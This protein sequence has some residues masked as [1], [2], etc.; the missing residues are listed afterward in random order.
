MQVIISSRIPK[1]EF[2]VSVFLWHTQRS[3]IAIEDL[4][5][6]KT[7]PKFP[8]PF[9]FTR[10]SAAAY[11]QISLPLICFILRMRQRLYEDVARKLFLEEI[12]VEPS[13]GTKIDQPVSTLEQQ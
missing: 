1:K 4:T 6:K 9:S 8:G 13:V 2:G 3:V 5:A 11:C 7:A 12:I 10:V